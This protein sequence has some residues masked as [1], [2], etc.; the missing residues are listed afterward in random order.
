VDEKIYVP[1]GS[2]DVKFADVEDE[3]DTD[4]ARLLWDARLYLMHNGNA[5]RLKELAASH[6]FYVHI[7]DYNLPGKNICNFNKYR[8]NNN[9]F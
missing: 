8:Y 9:L 7:E 4:E 6:G 2:L 5:R 1:L 3:S